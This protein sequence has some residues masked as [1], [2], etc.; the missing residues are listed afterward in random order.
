[1]RHVRIGDGEPGRVRARL[2]YQR[3]VPPLDPRSFGRRLRRPGLGE[4]SL[5]GSGPYPFRRPVRV[6][7]IRGV[8]LASAAEAASLRE[9]SHDAG[10]LLSLWLVAVLLAAAGC[11]RAPSVAPAPSVGDDARR[12]GITTPEERAGRTIY[13]RENCARCHTQFDRV[14]P[15]G[16]IAETAPPEAGWISRVGPDLGLTG[17]RRSDDWHYAHLYAPAVLVRGSPMPASRHLFREGQD[18][19]QAPTAEAIAL[20]AYLQSLGRDEIDPRA[21]LRR[22]EPEIPAPPPAGTDLL[23]R[24]DRL[25]GRHCAACHGDAGDGRGE[26]APLLLF[27]PR[28][29]TTAHYRFRSGGS[30]EPVAD[31]DLY[32]TITLG[33]GIGAAMPAF[34]WLPPRDRWALV[35]RIKQFSGRLRGL[36]LRAPRHGGDTPAADPARNGDRDALFR[37]GRRLW[38]RLGCDACHGR[39]GE[40]MDRRE[41]DASW[42]DL[43][44]NPIPRSGRLTHP[45]ALR[46]GA[47]PASI[48]RA[49]FGGG[50]AMPTY[51]EAVPDPEDRR[52]L[53]AYV[54]ALQDD[55]QGP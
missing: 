55:P 7:P 26:A 21:R 33:T 12:T 11:E 42:A 8:P 17:H 9:P 46:G 34:D 31:A 30:G 14:A 39:G 6:G 53:R 54:L 40:G 50:L 36:D 13:A 22:R 49:L 32:R 52:A 48:D 10:R 41:A 29:F 2:Q 15:D 25:Y 19:R 51:G 3:P 23:E 16:A 44:G 24:G 18:G 38:E 1:M 37:S 5:P 47:S 28:D 4:E 43:E 45:C 35:L 27:P 20:V